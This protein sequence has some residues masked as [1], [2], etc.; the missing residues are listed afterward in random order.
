MNSL[1]NNLIKNLPQKELP[2][3]VYPTVSHFP[4]YRSTFYS[5][6]KLDGKKLFSW[7]ANT[8]DNPLGEASHVETNDFEG[9]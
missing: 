8:A 3:P 7:C 4:H 6:N 5:H 9:S 1:K 2:T